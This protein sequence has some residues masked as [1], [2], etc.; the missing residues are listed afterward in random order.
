MGG[1]PIDLDASENVQVADTADITAM[2]ATWRSSANELPSKVNSLDKLKKAALLGPAQ[3]RE[4]KA[5]AARE[6]QR[7]SKARAREN[8][9]KAAAKEKAAATKAAA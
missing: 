5:A 2:E 7:A 3:Q 9:Q 8:T 1:D 6:T 4:S